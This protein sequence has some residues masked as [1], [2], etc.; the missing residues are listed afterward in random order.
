MSPPFAPVD[1]CLQDKDTRTD[2]T[3]FPGGGGSKDNFVFQRGIEAYFREYYNTN[4]KNLIFPVR[5]GG[6]GGVQHPNT[7]PL[8]RSAHETPLLI[9]DNCLV[10]LSHT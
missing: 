1:T 2:P 10:C 3:S 6:V 9:I 8:S 7:P 5:M 4:L